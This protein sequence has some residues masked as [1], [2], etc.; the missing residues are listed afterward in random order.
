MGLWQI[1]GSPNFGQKTRPNNNQQKKRT[2][3][4]EDFAVPADHR[5]KL[6]EWEKK[7]LNLVR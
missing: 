3:K 6:K 5:I 1:Q 4:I 7:Y 2:F